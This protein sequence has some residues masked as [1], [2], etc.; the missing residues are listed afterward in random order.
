MRTEADAQA[1]IAST[2][3]ERSGP[4][5][6]SLPNAPTAWNEAT[7][8]DPASIG[9]VDHDPARPEGLL[10]DVE[11]L[12]AQADATDLSKTRRGPHTR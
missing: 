2:V 7:A 8:G 1:P 6:Y 5:N 9:G 10:Q 11:G 12:S 3:L 4:R